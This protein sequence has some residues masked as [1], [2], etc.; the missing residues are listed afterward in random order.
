M[1]VVL[2][3]SYS[4][5]RW[6]YDSK[7]EDKQKSVIS[8]WF[9]C[10]LAVSSI[11]AVGLIVFAPSLS[12]LFLDSDEHSS[13]VTL[14][15]ITLPLL[16]FSTVAT[17]W[18]R[19]QRRAIATVL[20]QSIRTFGSIGV[21]ALFVLVLDQG[22]NGLWTARVIVALV[23]TVIAVALLRSWIAPRFANGPVLKEMLVFGMPLVPASVAAWITVSSDR[24]I[25]QMFHDNEEVGLYAISVTV[26]SV[27]L[28]LT[29]AF[30]LAWGP[31]AYS[32]MDDADAMRTYSKV[33]SLY[34]WLGAWIGTGLV[35]FA[36][37]VLVLLA[38][39]AY[40]PA[41]SSIPFLV[42]AQLAN[43]A[44]FIAAI[45]PGIAKKPSPLAVSTFVA[46]GVNLALNF[47]LIPSLGRDG[48][49]VSTLLSY[50]AGMILLFFLAQRIY[51]IGYRFRHM[52]IS[53]GF[54]AIIIVTAYFVLPGT[55]IASLA[56]RGLLCLLFI[57]LA[58]LMK[59]ITIDHM[60][61]LY[62]YLVGQFESRVS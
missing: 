48:A 9:W 54:A 30:Q 47:L 57:P 12:E 4:A 24:F 33:F 58:F 46:A 31:F 62:R 1:L 29:S 13:V 5:G 41:I 17:N 34:S 35:L 60:R 49:A 21:I 61:M 8:S 38:T 37:A 40:Y 28:L 10:Q 6:F 18:L 14:A 52:V 55:D 15:L 53:F 56:A 51:P 22:L 2:G 20:Y 36:P 23:A 32:I 27:I 16:T 26:A 25:I 3:L 11:V 7:D 19:L 39:P 44:I 43:G 45:G 59:V 50:L 42:F